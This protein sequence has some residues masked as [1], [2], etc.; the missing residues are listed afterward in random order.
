MHSLGNSRTYVRDCT[1]SI[2]QNVHSL[3]GQ[4]CHKQKAPAV[5]FQGC[6]RSNAYFKVVFMLNV[7]TTFQAHDVHDSG[8]RSEAYC[9]LASAFWL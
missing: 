3:I 8:G 9:P 7:C 1:Q 5:T 4:I 6:Q 2:G